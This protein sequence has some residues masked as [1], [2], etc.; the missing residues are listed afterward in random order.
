MSEY[1]P[2]TGRLNLSHDEILV[3]VEYIIRGVGEK[4]FVIEAEPASIA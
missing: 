3:W 4:L 1:I 2:P